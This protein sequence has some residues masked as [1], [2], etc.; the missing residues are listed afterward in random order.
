MDTILLIDYDLG[1]LLTL[2]NILMRAGYTVWPARD[3][4]SAAALIFEAGIAVDLIIADAGGLLAGESQLPS[5][6]AK[7]TPIVATTE[8]DGDIDG[9]TAERLGVVRVAPRPVTAEA[10]DAGEWIEMVRSVMAASRAGR[11]HA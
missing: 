3:V 5:I 6:G 9:S 8:F 1:F 4:A 10:L 11:R 2:A 7:R